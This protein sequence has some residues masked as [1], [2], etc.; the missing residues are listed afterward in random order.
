MEES[1]FD[2]VGNAILY[3]FI[4]FKCEDFYV[5]SGTMTDGKHIFL[6]VCFMSRPYF[7]RIKTHKMNTR[8]I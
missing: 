5:Y 6:F 3:G 4:K 1:D 8:F 7:L 2:F